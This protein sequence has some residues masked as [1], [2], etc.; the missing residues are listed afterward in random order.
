MNVLL[1]FVGSLLIIS[2]AVSIV[3]I[4]YVFGMNC[5]ATSKLWQKAKAATEFLSGKG[6]HF[7]Q[8][9]SAHEVTLNEFTFSVLKDPVRGLP[10]RTFYR[11]LRQAAHGNDHA[12]KKLELLCKAVDEKQREVT[13]RRESL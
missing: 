9:E 7:T 11:L 13:K 4:L 1:D 5:Y 8:L 2:F 10:S 12:L 3:V 6:L